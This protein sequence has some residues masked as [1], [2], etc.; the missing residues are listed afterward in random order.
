MTETPES[1][2]Q[3]LDGITESCKTYGMKINAKK[4]KTMH[5]RK[6]KK[7]VSKLIE[8]SPL[9]QK[10]KYQYLRHI[11]TEDVSMEKEIDIRT[12]KAR[13]KFWKHKELLRRNIN[14]DT[15]KSIL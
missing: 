9:G 1:L 7:K 12:E 13:A 4:T 2:Q 15:K 3:M 11:L 5:I 10:T 6:E 14:I 8:G